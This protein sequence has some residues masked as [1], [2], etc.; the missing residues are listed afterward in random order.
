MG[1]LPGR[2]IGVQVIPRLVLEAI[3]LTTE[4]LGLEHEYVCLNPSVLRAHCEAIRDSSTARRLI[5]G[6]IGKPESDAFDAVGATPWA[7]LVEHSAGFLMATS[8]MR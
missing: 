2:A 3:T 1:T 6:A 4:C 7:T 8:P 5:A